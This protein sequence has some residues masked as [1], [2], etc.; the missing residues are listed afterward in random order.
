MA[1]LFLDEM[2]FR[3]VLTLGVV[4]DGE[5]GV[6]L[7]R[8]GCGSYRRSLFCHVSLGSLGLGFLHQS[9]LVES[10]FGVLIVE[11]NKLDDWGEII[12]DREIHGVHDRIRSY[13]FVLGSFTL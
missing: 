10:I 6:N 5:L 4:S 12:P 1:L 7:A 13:I 9:R 3:E 2:R 11:V 8:F